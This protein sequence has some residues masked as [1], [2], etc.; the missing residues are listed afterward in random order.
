MSLLI[1]VLLLMTLAYSLGLA[2]PVDGRAELK[3]V[4]AI[5]EELQ[6]ERQGKDGPVRIQFPQ[7]ARL[8]TKISTQVE[9]F[10]PRQVWVALIQYYN[11]SLPECFSSLLQ[12]GTCLKSRLIYSELEFVFC[13]TL[14]N[15]F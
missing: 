1:P 13:K 6:A 15:L 2:Q 11:Q 12:S 9:Y 14:F 5:L 3:K 7:E 8:L 4:Q 10:N